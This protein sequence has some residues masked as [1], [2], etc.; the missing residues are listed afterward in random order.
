VEE[1]G[2]Y[3]LWGSIELD[4]RLIC[5]CHGRI[6]SDHKVAVQIGGD[7]L[8]FQIPV[9]SGATVRAAMRQ[10]GRTDDNLVVLTRGGIAHA[11]AAD[12]PLSDGDH[13]CLIPLEFSGLQAPEAS[14]G[15]ALPD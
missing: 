7:V 9:P 5:Q 8:S 6:I 13:L 3:I 15:A 14:C 2:L 4:S 12:T 11:A 1:K 10:F